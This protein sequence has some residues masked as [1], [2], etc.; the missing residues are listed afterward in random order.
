MHTRKLLKNERSLVVSWL[1][2]KREARVYK[3]Y[4][5][6]YKYN[7]MIM[8]DGGVCVYL[9]KSKVFSV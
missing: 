3:K 5:L 1:K 4:V 2:N 6:V 9:W 7:A 8:C